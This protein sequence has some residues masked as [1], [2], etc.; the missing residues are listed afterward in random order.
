MSE[1]QNKPK[2]DVRAAFTRLLIVL[3]VLIGF[4]IYSY[5]WTVTDIDL[6]KPQEA[7]RQENVGNAL[8]ELL[9]PRIFQQERELVEINTPFLME[10][11]TEGVELP[12]ITPLESGAIVTIE[13]TCGE[14]GDIL[15]VTISN[16]EPHADTRIRWL[17]PEGQSR[18]REDLI[19]GREEIVLSAAGSF[20]AQIEVPRIR[21]TEGMIHQVAIR[22][23]I[24]VGGATFSDITQLTILRMTETI[25]MALLATSIAI[26]IASFISFFA[27]RNLMRPIKLGVGNLLVAFLAFCLGWAIGSSLLTPLGNFGVQLGYG[28]ESGAG[29][30]LIVLVIV[31]VA[32]VF[33]LRAIN[34]RTTNPTKAKNFTT[35]KTSTDY[36]RMVANSLVI[37]LVLVL[38]IG[39][40]A[41]LAIFISEQLATFGDSLRPEFLKALD[42]SREEFH[43]LNP[44]EWIQNAV[45]DGIM[46]IGVLLHTVGTLTQLLM[47]VVVAL[48]TAFSMSSVIGNLV[49]APLRQLPKNIGQV[50]GGVL[51]ALA[52]AILLGLLGLLGMSAALLGL[53]APIVAGIM[54][55]ETMIAHHRRVSPKK[56]L[57]KNDTHSRRLLQLGW[58]AISAVAVF[59][60][61]FNMLAV[62]RALIDGTLPPTTTTNIFG[63]ELFTYVARS[64]LIGAVLG[65]AGGARVGIHSNFPLGSTLYNISR[66]L[67]NTVRSIEPLIMGLV[68]VVWVGIGPFAGVL[69]LTLHSVAALGKLYSEQ[70]EN[71]DPGPLEAIQS[72]GASWLQTVVYAVI[73]QIVPPYIAF[74]M[75]RWDI[76]VRMSTIIGF[77]GGGGIGLLLQQQINLLRYRDAGVA[78]LAIA[79][80]VSL[81]DYASAYIREKLT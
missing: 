59:V 15:N 49:S 60:F 71:I 36:A 17:P 1:Q 47:P 27:A 14:P 46:A 63:L 67:L 72:T 30:G 28:Q 3:A 53:L 5:G 19:S 13:P 16:F 29:I 44:A 10:C 81:L 26:P 38:S 68:F 25:F 9:S 61:T 18:P 48:I 62:G 66:T 50:V 33:S 58:Y 31:L 12:E 76:N 43:P 4:V 74:T 77:V 32:T 37:T 24:P 75:Y 54:A 34:P 73:P 20:T 7:Q 70:V 80:V 51:G 35:T 11:D 2:S 57:T 79:L 42:I 40:V 64:A 45:A 39:I 52:G 22:S 55:G 8:R 65:G 78:V 69:A 41:G 23:A 6:D 21:G 56:V